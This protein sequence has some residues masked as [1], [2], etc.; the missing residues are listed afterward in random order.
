MKPAGR[1]A[2]FHVY[3]L[4]GGIPLFVQPSERFKN[5]CLRLFVR[6]RLG[7]RTSETAL[8]PPVLAR[9]T[10][11]HD[12]MAAITRHL[13]ALYGAS[14][15]IDASKVGEEHVLSFRV[16][17]VA[18]RHLPGKR[19]NVRRGLEFLGELALS[20]AMKGASL[21]PDYVEQEAHNLRREIEDLS[22]DRGEWAY[23]RCVEEMCAGE[24]YAVHE[25]GTARGAAEATPGSVTAWHRELLREAPMEL[26]VAGR[27]K[28]EEIARAAAEVFAI[29]GR[30]ATRSLPPPVVDVPVKGAKRVREEMEVEQGK[31]VMGYRTYATYR[32]EGSTALSFL[33]GMFG[34]F[35]HS[36]LFIN[37]RER[38]GMAYSAGTSVDKLK[39]LLVAHAGIEAANEERCVALIEKELASFREG[40]IGD[41]E[42][43][44]T[45]RAMAERARSVLD[46][47]TRAIHG[48]FER[49]VGGRVQTVTEVLG[50]IG[51][52]TKAEV[53][54]AAKRLKLDTVYF[55]APKK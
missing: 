28:P 37:L 12:T 13:D 29:R 54:E 5:V 50:E 3:E 20:P 32:D 41:E 11:R 15:A 7:E 40:R 22:S 18:D 55:L 23:I 27:V 47:P 43:E 34:G 49:R 31:L 4:D 35:P 17:A 42:M 26:Y 53:A 2:D 39:G 30:R 9:G 46:S 52:A 44:A 51:K 6:T 36:R 10:R 1:W 21:R 16:D 19:G 38:D 33:N 24:P 25:L 8:L 45:R 48:L 14:Y